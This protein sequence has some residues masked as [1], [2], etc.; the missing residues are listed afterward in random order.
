[1]KMLEKSFSVI[2]TA[3]HLR[4]DSYFPVKA[5][6]T[7]EA[8]LELLHVLLDGGDDNPNEI[9]GLGLGV[10]SKCMSFNP[11]VFFFSF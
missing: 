10:I 5:K 6:K 7:M 1:M 4:S 8:M 3:K 2:I 9:F 11:K